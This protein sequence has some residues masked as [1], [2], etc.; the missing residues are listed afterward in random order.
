MAHSVVKVIETDIAESL[1]LIVGEDGVITPDKETALSILGNRPTT[2]LNILYMNKTT[3]NK[4]DVTLDSLMYINSDEVEDA[5]YNMDEVSRNLR[6]LQLDHD[7]TAFKSPARPPVEEEVDLEDELAQTLRLLD[8]NLPDD[9]VEQKMSQI[10]KQKEKDASKKPES[11]KVN[12]KATKMITTNQ[13]LAKIAQ[14]AIEVVEKAAAPQTKASTTEDAEEMEEDEGD[15]ESSDEEEP[16]DDEDDSDFTL[17]DEKPAKPPKRTPLKRTL[18]TSEKQPPKPP[19][20]LS[21]IRPTTPKTPKIPGGKQPPPKQTQPSPVTPA[22]E[23][24]TPAKPAVVV[25]TLQQEVSPAATE[26]EVAAV[27]QKPQLESI[28]RIVEKK[29][30]PPK[31]EKKVPKPILDDFALFSTPDIIRRVGAGKDNAPVTPTSDTPTN[32]NKPP[33]PTTPSA[34]SPKPAKISP[35]SRSRTTSIDSKTPNKLQSQKRHSSDSKLSRDTSAIATTPLRRSSV[36]KVDEGTAANV[37]VQEFDPSGSEELTGDVGAAL[38]E[39]PSAEDIRAIIQS[40]STKTFTTYDGGATEGAR[41]AEPIPSATSISTTQAAAIDPVTV[42]SLDHIDQ[43]LLL[44]NISPDLITDDILYQVAQSLVDNT[45]LQNA[46]DKMEVD[47][48]VVSGFIGGNQN[49]TTGVVENTGMNMTNSITTPQQ[50]PALQQS[51]TPAQQIV[52][53]DGRVITLPPVE[54]PTT[55]SRNRRGPN[56]ASSLMAE[57][58]SSPV[59]PTPSANASTINS[60]AVTVG[61]TPT[62]AMRLIKT[63]VKPLDD[64]HVSGNELDSSDNDDDDGDEEDPN[65]LWCIC[66]QPHN[67]RFMICC[68]TCE[69]WYHGKCV[70]VTKAMGQTMESEGKEWKC[71]YCKDLS[72]KRPKAAARRIRKASRTSSE[73]ASKSSTSTASTPV[74]NR[75]AAS[76]QQQQQQRQQQQIGK[77]V[78]QQVGESRVTGGCLI[79]GKPTSNNKLF[80]SDECIVKHAANVEKKVVVYDR[81]THKLLSGANAPTAAN[82]DRWLKDHPTYEV[83]RTK[84]ASPPQAQPQLQMAQ[85]QL[86]QKKQFIRQGPLTQSKLK[87]VRNDGTPAGGVSLALQKK[88]VNIGLLKHGPGGPQRQPGGVPTL[89]RKQ[90]PPGMKLVPSP[91]LARAQQTILN[92]AASPLYVPTAPKTVKLIPASSLP[93]YIPTPQGKQQSTITKAKATIQTKLNLSVVGDG[94]PPSENRRKSVSVNAFIRDKAP[95]SG[96]KKERQL[97]MPTKTPIARQAE[98]VGTA[99]QKQE[100]IREGIRKSLLEQLQNRL[101]LVEDLNLTDDELSG[102]S[103]EIE[104]QLYKCFGD[105]GQKYRN[106]YRSLIFNIK[107]LKNQTLWRKIC[108]NAINPYQLVRLS[109]DDLA[110]QE[111]A[112][113]RE[114]ETKHQLDMIKKS[115]LELMS[116]TRQYVFKTHKG[117]QVFEDEKP[118]ENLSEVISDLG[119]DST[120]DRDGDRSTK[121]KKSSSKS[122]KRD[123]DR[124]KDRSRDRDRKSGKD[125]TDSKERSKERSRKRRSRSRDRSDRDKKRSRSRDRDKERRSSHKSSRHKKDLDGNKL[126]KKS[127][128][129]L[130]QLVD[131]H[132]LKPFEDKLWKHVPQDDLLPNASLESDSDHEPTSTV[133]IPTPPHSVDPEEAAASTDKSNT[134]AATPRSNDS[135]DKFDIPAT[136]SPTTSPKVP[137]TLTP[138]ITKPSPVPAIP[139]ASSSSSSNASSSPGTSAAQEPLWRGSINMVD[140]AEISITAHEVSGD[141]KGLTQE[142]PPSL[143]I[144][145]RISPD[146]VWD[147]IGNMK[148]SNSKVISLLRLNATNVEEKM[149]YIALYSYLSS[150]NRLGVVKVMNKVVKDFYI[151]PL[152]SHRP[153]PQALLPLNGPGFEESRP[154]LLLGIVIRHKRKRLSVDPL[155]STTPSIKRVKVDVVITGSP[156]D[157]SYSHTSSDKETSKEKDTTATTGSSRS[158]TPPPSSTPRERDPR[159]SRI[160]PPSANVLVS[161]EAEEEKTLDSIEASDAK[162]VEVTEKKQQVKVEEQMQVAEEEKTIEDE[163]EDDDTIDDDEPY[164]PED[165]DPDS[166]IVIA[167]SS[168]L[169]ATDI[170]SL[171]TGSVKA[172]SF[173]ESGLSSSQSF[174]PFTSKFDSIPG[175][176]DTTSIPASTLELQR[177]MAELDQKIAMSKAEIDNMSQDIASTA[178]TDIGTSVLANIALPSDLQQIL[179]NI[180][181]IGGTALKES[182]AKTPDRKISPLHNPRWSPPDALA[183]KVVRPTLSND[184]PMPLIL[185]RL[186]SRNTIGSPQGALLSPSIPLNLPAK[187]AKSQMPPLQPAPSYESTSSISVLSSLTEADLIRKAAEMLG[188]VKASVTAPPKAKKIKMDLSGLVLGGVPPLPVPPPLG[189]ISNPSPSIIGYQTIP[190]IPPPPP[191]ISAP[192]VPKKTPVEMAQPPIPGLEDEIL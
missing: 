143:D 102:I 135:D 87:L 167:D 66:N 79:C 82:L 145:G 19:L 142:L 52:R 80:C 182:A 154:H 83:V 63:P 77:A 23:K 24:Q 129:L 81:R 17:D 156:K 22:V 90:L 28:S 100:N 35:E 138:S 163:A 21:K 78:K 95:G 26:P 2:D 152:A 125:K 85:Q 171:L 161:K 4:L 9:E 112:L 29:P 106:K 92:A 48:A 111:L 176:E 84:K 15:D 107:D 1:T 146:T 132:I 68:D 172:S 179:E 97:P 155:A 189:Y 101:K 118:K 190:V 36:N 186:S 96:G 108:E 183:S 188:E 166:I 69:E 175:L 124:S 40:D 169:N 58:T 71:L 148:S 61:G 99:A 98:S 94:T 141:C 115:E 126:D 104:S 120:L 105:T 139:P 10:N 25:E 173:I 158:Y 93:Q 73:S 185:P 43:T 62:S 6:N 41:N 50:S 134:I 177:K 53:P 56:I 150:R 12:I 123:R 191:K 181:T 46:I 187:P 119:A 51:I 164:S 18:S 74:S 31:K 45:V 86:Q 121:D 49:A 144:V 130:E 16:S 192:P 59:T 133:T 55:R 159:K 57:V 76:H 44:D 113:W 178:T 110:S 149:P 7:Y 147:Y 136:P 127:T 13:K 32:P 8:G 47:P 153:I 54:R 60:P 27:E 89:I 168:H 34:S 75:T 103:E 5:D 128:E 109:S 122:S 174:Q 91:N 162:K 33:T 67:N 64:D 114:R 165:S 11:P 70:N 157:K 170:S 137:P 14:K 116:C 3:G 72:L 184:L 88:G 65:K 39:V 180:K 140:V 42:S 131:K 117:E 30:Q 37:C 20:R 38:D 151:L 160:V